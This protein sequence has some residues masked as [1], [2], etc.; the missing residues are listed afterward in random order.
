MKKINDGEKY[1][2][3]KVLEFSHK[4]EKTGQDFYKCIC[5]CGNEKTVNVH[6]LITGHTKSCGCWKLK[7][8]KTPERKKLVTK[9]GKVNTTIY[10]VWV[11]M[12]SRCYNPNDKA[13]SYYG[14]R[15]IAVSEDWMNFENFYRDMGDKPGREY[16]LERIDNE[17]GYSRENCRWATMLEQGQNRRGNRHISFNGET[18]TIAGWARRLGISHTSMSKR[19]KNWPV[20][21][22]LTTIK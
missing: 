7:V 14:G 20:E 22:A 3:L 21:K 18:L 5:D 17:K 2:M 1:N 11:R 4:D 19:L 16:S 10:R 8:M 15:G 13:Y 9:H 6:K 12:K